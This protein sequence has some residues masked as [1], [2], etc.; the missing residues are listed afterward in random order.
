MPGRTWEALQ[1]ARHLSEQDMADDEYEE[2]QDELCGMTAAQYSCEVPSAHGTDEDHAEAW[3]ILR[4][5]RHDMTA[6]EV[7]AIVGRAES[8]LE[9]INSRWIERRLTSLGIENQRR[10]G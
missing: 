8:V 2:C 5:L 3:D 1:L 7:T 9:A 6:E 10:Y 4:C